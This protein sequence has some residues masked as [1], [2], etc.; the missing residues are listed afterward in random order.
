MY[1]FCCLQ[2]L[3]SFS[4]VDGPQCTTFVAWTTVLLSCVV[5]L[6][7]HD[8]I[9]LL[10]TSFSS[11]IL[12][13]QGTISNI[14]KNW[15][16]DGCAG[17]SYILKN[18]ADD[19]NCARDTRR[20]FSWITLGICLNLHSYIYYFQMPYENRVGAFYG[21][22]EWDLPFRFW[23]NLTISRCN[24]NA[25]NPFSYVYQNH[26]VLRRKSNYFSFVTTRIPMFAMQTTMLLRSVC[27]PVN[28]RNVRSFYGGTEDRQKM[29]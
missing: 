24:L 10:T 21:W 27:D 23:L 11:V 17:V 6:P 9:S 1:N 26:T 19:N 28:R 5:L 18:W 29:L 4:I 12:L 13:C 14:L 20:F 16:Y 7:I 8:L 3:L 15:A 25:S 2:I 22:C